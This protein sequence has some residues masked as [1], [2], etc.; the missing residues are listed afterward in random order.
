MT[1]YVMLLMVAVLVTTSNILDGN[2][3]MAV[4]GLLLVTGIALMF[5]NALEGAAR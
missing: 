4:A 3:K 2:K 5:A 1:G